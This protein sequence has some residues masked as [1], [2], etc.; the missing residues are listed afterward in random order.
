MQLSLGNTYQLRSTA[1]SSGQF[2]NTFSDFSFQ[3]KT[4]DPRILRGG[5]PFSNQSES[6]RISLEIVENVNSSSQIIPA[7][8]GAWGNNRLSSYFY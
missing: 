3:I 1:L 6:L 4:H 5:G 2:K 7:T 8:S